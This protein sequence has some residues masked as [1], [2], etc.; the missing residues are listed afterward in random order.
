MESRFDRIEEKVDRVLDI[1]SSI[2]KD[3]Q[4]HIYRTELA[5][6][7]IQELKQALQPVQSHVLVVQ[8]MGKVLAW[9]GSIAIAL[10]AVY[11][12]LMK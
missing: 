10:T 8:G 3:L 12:S 7:A 9:L 1:Q 6:E 5:E 11:K 4:H 2:Q